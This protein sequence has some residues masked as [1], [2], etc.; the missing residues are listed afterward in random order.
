VDLGQDAETA[1]PKVPRDRGEASEQDDGAPPHLHEPN[2][3]ALFRERLAQS[4]GS[5][6]QVPV[7]ATTSPERLRA[8]WDRDVA[9]VTFDRFAR[10]VIAALQYAYDQKYGVWDDVNDLRRLYPDTWHTKILPYTSTLGPDARILGVGINDG[11]EIR[12]LFKDRRAKLDL[13]DLSAKAIGSLAAQLADYTHIRSFIGRFEEWEP[14]YDEY[15]LFFSLRT[16]NC[17]AVN[18]VA[19]VRKSIT[20][21]KPGGV[22]IYS[23]ANGYVQM[24]NGVPTALNGMFSHDTGLIEAERPQE[25]AAEIHAEIVAAGATTLKFEV[26]PSE[27]FVVAANNRPARA[28]HDGLR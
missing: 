15:D 21:V 5:A 23:V 7:A 14:A 28:G 26:C 4:Y 20:L 12:Q 2:I 24:D 3:E 9:S 16:L 10:D 27:I 1:M 19:C 11:R 13:L 6:V 22:L 17:T 25:I 8:L 18:R